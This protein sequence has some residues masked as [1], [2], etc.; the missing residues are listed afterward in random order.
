[1]CGCYAPR[2]PTVA[3][4]LVTRD[5]HRT[6]QKRQTLYIA[7]V[8]HAR[9]CDRRARRRSVREAGAVLLSQTVLL[10]ASMT[11]S[12]SWAADARL[13]GLGIRPC[14]T[15]IRSRARTAFSLSLA[16]GRQIYAELSRRVTSVAL[17]AYVLDIPGGFGKARVA[18]GAAAPD[19]QGGW[20]VVDRNGD[21][22]S[23]HDELEPPQH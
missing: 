16:A 8:N 22:R 13:A 18:E 21:K 6:S 15:I 20:T 10:K 23:Y 4:D 5:R 19:G 9:S 2:A 17:P 1:M 7:H 11:T 12:T 14:V 3:P